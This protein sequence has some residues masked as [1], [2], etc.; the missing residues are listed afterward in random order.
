MTALETAAIVATVAST[1]VT[2]YASY[3]QGQAQQAASEYNA[4]VAEH[5]A[6]LARQAAAIREE[7]QREHD[8]RLMARARAIYGVSGVSALEGSPLFVQ[9][10]N[11]RQAELNALRLRYGGEVQATGFLSQAGLDRFLGETAATQATIGAGAT[12]LSGF[13]SAGPRLFT[14]AGPTVPR[15]GSTES[16]FGTGPI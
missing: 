13:G 8:R 6:T 10:D 12:L 2:A 4:Q 14:G 16:A 5:Q 3:Q 9:L 15:V 1:A 11:A 7:Q